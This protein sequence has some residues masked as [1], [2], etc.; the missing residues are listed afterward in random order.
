MV[1]ECFAFPLHYTDK[2]LVLAR[3]VHVLQLFSGHARLN[4][5]RVSFGLDLVED[6]LE[7]SCHLHCFDNLC[8]LEVLSL[9][10]VLD[11]LVAVVADDCCEGRIEATFFSKDLSVSLSQFLPVLD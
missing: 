1:E 2:F 7:D 5:T 9:F 8:I 10:E 4:L 11:C 6:T 3:K